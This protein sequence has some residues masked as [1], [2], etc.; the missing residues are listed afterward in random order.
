MNLI[1][2]LFFG[3]MGAQ[4][5]DMAITGARIYTLNPQAPVA[6]A[7]AVK[8][9]KVLAVGENVDR[10]VGP[11]ARRIDA[12]GATILPGLIDSHAH[13]LGLGESLEVLD[14]RA[15]KSP[16]AVAEKVRR[17]AQNLKPGEWIRGRSWDQTTFPTR[18]F[19]SA[20]PLTAAAPQNPV[21]LT[22]VDG[23]AA[24]AEGCVLLHQATK[25]VS[26]GADVISK[27]ASRWMVATSAKWATIPAWLGRT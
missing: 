13:M 11:S 19:P 10:Y 5:A 20:A 21:Y 14:L 18:E 15:D 17:E 6:S 16:Q 2:A 22:R 3:L 24:W 7:I 26:V 12:K 27:R 25:L 8:D 1:L 9:G 23:H 4:A